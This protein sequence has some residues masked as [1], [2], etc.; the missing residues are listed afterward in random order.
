M[1]LSGDRTDLSELTLPEPELRALY[2]E[3]STD[4]AQQL[5]H[6]TQAAMSSDSLGTKEDRSA[7]SIR[8]KS[9]DVLAMSAPGVPAPQSS[10]GFPLDELRY[11][12]WKSINELL[13]EA[14]RYDK[15]FQ[16]AV[17]EAIAKGTKLPSRKIGWPRDDEFVNSFGLSDFHPPSIETQLEAN[18][19]RGD[20]NIR[21]DQI[22]TG[23]ATVLRL[24]GRLRG[25][26]HR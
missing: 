21:D 11:E 12:N 4:P 7:Q 3:L 18:N 24:R 26:G 25:I 5:Q 14:T 20:L 9:Q 17:D 15:A 8:N 1:S 22:K 6:D 23:R 10:T 13:A 19:A 2:D 16:S